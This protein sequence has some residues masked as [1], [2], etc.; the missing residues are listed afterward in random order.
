[1]MAM[2]ENRI[3]E[4]S[5]ANNSFLFYLFKMKQAPKQALN[6][7]PCTVESLVIFNQN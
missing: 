7:F 2:E 6:V 5:T 4:N 1:M 3:S